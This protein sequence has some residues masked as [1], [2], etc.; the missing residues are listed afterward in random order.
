[1]PQQAIL[2]TAIG[3]AVSAAMTA[4]LIMGFVRW[5]PPTLLNGSAAAI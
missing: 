5:Q 2:A 4:R 3:V 1:V